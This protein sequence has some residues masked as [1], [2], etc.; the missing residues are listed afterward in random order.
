LRALLH[1]ELRLGFKPSGSFNPQGQTDAGFAQLRC[2][3]GALRALRVGLAGEGLGASYQSV[4][5]GFLLSSLGLRFGSRAEGRGSPPLVQHD[6]E[7]D[8]VA[9]DGEAVH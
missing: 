8:V 1:T 4:G 5:F 9:E 2:P 6:E 7:H 3:V